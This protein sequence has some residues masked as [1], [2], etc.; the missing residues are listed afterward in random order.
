MSELDASYASHPLRGVTRRALWARMRGRRLPIVAGQL[1]LAGPVQRLTVTRDRWAIPHVRTREV[2]DAAFALGFCQG[3]DRSLQ[4]TLLR[5]WTRARLSSVVGAGALAADALALR[6]NLG[7]WSSRVLA[8]LEPASR[9]LLEA[10]ARGVEA[11][12][13]LGRDARCPGHHLL[14]AH[15]GPFSAGDA[16]AISVMRLLLSSLVPS[17]SDASQV[18]GLWGLEE[19]SLASGRGELAEVLRRASAA[20]SLPSP[21][22]LAH[23]DWLSREVAGAVWVGTPLLAL[24]HD[25]NVAWWPTVG[26]QWLELLGTKS[27][28]TRSTLKPRRARSR[29]VEHLRFEPIDDAVDEV[30][31]AIEACL[32]VWD[33][34]PGPDAP[35]LS[36]GREARGGGRSEVAT[37]SAASTH[38]P[39]ARA[40]SLPHPVSP[41]RPRMA[42]AFSLGP[43]V[44]RD[45]RREPAPL[46]YQLDA[47]DP[48]S[49]RFSYPGGQ[50]GNPLS[51]HYDDLVPSWLRGGGVPIVVRDSDIERLARSRLILE[52]YMR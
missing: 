5:A 49:G 30:T 21:Y 47:A 8:S 41:L 18:W 42:P 19:D 40:L 9:E 13:S 16:V 29:R 38:A 4:L 15:P 48:E 39:L 45:G 3:Q 14:R 33:R 44:W 50:S 43:L 7:A 32:F 27:E 11:G 28:S 17:G 25:R 12:E 10:F 34:S 20:P 46:V 2:R 26:P 31:R 52:P 37:Q 6:L 51:A 1:R 24:G 22:Y 23:L 35:C 36:V